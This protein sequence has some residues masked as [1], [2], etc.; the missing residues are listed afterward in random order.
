MRSMGRGSFDDLGVGH[1]EAGHVRPV[2]VHIRV[3]RGRGQRAGDV[4]AAAG[5]GLDRAVGH[6]AVKAGITTR[7][8]EAACC[9]AS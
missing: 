8:P 6:D 3:E 2:L 9:S 4:A 7:R 5:E 1:E